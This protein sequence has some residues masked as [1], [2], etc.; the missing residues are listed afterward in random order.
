M[1]EI[2]SRKELKNLLDWYD[3]LIRTGK[4]RRTIVTMIYNSYSSNLQGDSE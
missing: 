1:I 4:N 3:E 2:I